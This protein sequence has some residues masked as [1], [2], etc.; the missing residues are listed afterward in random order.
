MPTPTEQK[1]I[2]MHTDFFDRTQLAIDNGFFL[3]AI[4]REYAAMEGRLEILLGVLGAPCNKNLPFEK[5]KDIKISHRIRCLSTYY[6]NA[7]EV[8]STK[9][10][11]KFFSDLNGWIKQRNTYIHGLYKN[12]IEY[13]E[14]SK[15]CKA[16]AEDGL[17]LVRMLY[18]ETK[19]LR[20]HIK[21][22]PEFVLP[23]DAICRAKSCSLIKKESS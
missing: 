23:A 7:P 5:R 9:L 18:N 14:R 22:H 10:T 8:G 15:K 13:Q 3:E 1:Q 19:R 16:M 17:L 6:K 20:R 4:F 2:E 11:K 21:N 12:E